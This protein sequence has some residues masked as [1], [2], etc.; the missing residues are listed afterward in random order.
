MA[1]TEARDIWSEKETIFLPRGAGK[2]D[3]QFVCINGRSFL[4][5]KGKPVE[6]P[7]PVYEVLMRAIEYEDASRERKE[8]LTDRG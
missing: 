2:E 6:V 5:P 7:R 1:K 4:V 8:A 3:T